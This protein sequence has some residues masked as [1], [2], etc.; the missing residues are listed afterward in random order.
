MS[1]ILAFSYK[2]KLNYIKIEDIQNIS[3]FMIACSCFLS[4]LCYNLRPLWY[5]ND[6]RGGNLRDHLIYYYHL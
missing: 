1:D 3:L 2:Y 5:G 6:D 4:Y